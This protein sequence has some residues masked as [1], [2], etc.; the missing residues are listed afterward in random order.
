MTSPCYTLNL[1]KSHWSVKNCV[2]SKLFYAI[3]ELHE[4]NV[5]IS[6][7][8]NVWIMFELKYIFWKNAFEWDKK[9]YHNGLLLFQQKCTYLQSKY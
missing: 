9:I 8:F 6:S 1:Y 2:W 3:F 4:F 7:L 5:W